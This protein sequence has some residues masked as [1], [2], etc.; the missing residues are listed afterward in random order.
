MH[1]HRTR[2][3]SASDGGSAPLDSDDGASLRGVR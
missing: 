1:D 3:A 2:S